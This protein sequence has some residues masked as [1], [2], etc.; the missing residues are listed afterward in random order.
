[1]GFA[2][3]N[4][5]LISYFRS[6]MISNSTLYPPC[7][8]SRQPL[9]EG[10][11]T[12]GSHMVWPTRTQAPQTHCSQ[13][14]SYH[15]RRPT[16][17]PPPPRRACSNYPLQPQSSWGS[18]VYSGRAQGSWHWKKGGAGCWNCRWPQEEKSERG[19][20]KSERWETAGI[21][22]PPDR[23][24]PKGWQA[25][26]GRFISA[27][28]LYYCNP[29]DLWAKIGFRRRILR[30]L[31]P[32]LQSLCPRCTPPRLHAKSPPRNAS[33]RLTGLSASPVPTSDTR[34]PE[35]HGQQR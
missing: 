25:Q 22:V 2:H 8:P 14:Q 6:S 29:L 3:N 28:L 21:Q 26:E 5:A 4:G 12:P 19:G 35:R 9:Q 18:R 17:H 1:M 34:V 24:P 27:Y 30:L 7:S 13:S 11:A 33:S 16:S 32:V 15:S 20:Q 31:P 23:L 10:L